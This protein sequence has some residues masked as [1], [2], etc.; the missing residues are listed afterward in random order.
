MKKI[1]KNA[2]NKLVKGKRVKQATIILLKK[3]A[4]SNCM[5]AKECFSKNSFS[6][7]CY[8]VSKACLQMKAMVSNIKAK[9]IGSTISTLLKNFLKN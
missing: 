3:T 6:K 9:K 7:K 5:K 2:I 1:M 8:I 4:R